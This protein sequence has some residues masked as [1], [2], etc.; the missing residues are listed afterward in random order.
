MSRYGRHRGRDD[1]LSPH[2]FQSAMGCDAT[3]GV[4]CRKEDGYLEERISVVPQ[5]RFGLRDSHIWR[6]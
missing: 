2:Q 5:A 4:E 1:G 3:H 6:S